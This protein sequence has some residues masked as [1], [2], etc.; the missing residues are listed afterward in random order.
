MITT[1]GFIIFTTQSNCQRMDMNEVN[2]DLPC[3]D[4]RDLEMVPG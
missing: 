4:E 2:E 1:L 3:G